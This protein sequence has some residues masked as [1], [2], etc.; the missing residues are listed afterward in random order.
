MPFLTAA[1]AAPVLS[2]ELSTV[3]SV[4]AIIITILLA[5]LSAMAGLGLLG[6]RREITRNDEA[7]RELRSDIK[8]VEADV[9]KL[10]AGQ[11][12]IE[13]LLE[14]MAGGGPDRR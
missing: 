6:L 11:A 14:G 7:H 9:Q 3:V 8:A 1:N 5:L 13:G 2:I 4:A 10:L 12:R